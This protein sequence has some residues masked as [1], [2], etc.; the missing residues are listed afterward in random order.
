[1]L[2]STFREKEGSVIEPILLHSAIVGATVFCVRHML[3]G[4]TYSILPCVE[5]GC[6]LHFA[7]AIM[8][9]IWKS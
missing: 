7:V 5:T 2:F 1:M 8:A 4:F 9:H 6:L 3:I